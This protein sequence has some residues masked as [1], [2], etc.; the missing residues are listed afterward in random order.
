MNLDGSQQEKVLDESMIG[1]N[2]SVNV[3]TILIVK[4]VAWISTPCS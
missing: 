2:I 3:F 4:M 1:F